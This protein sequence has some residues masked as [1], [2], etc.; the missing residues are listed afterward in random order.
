MIEWKAVDSFRW[1]SSDP[2]ATVMRACPVCSRPASRE[3]VS[4]PGFQY[5]TDDARLSKRIHIRDVVCDACHAVY[6]NPVLTDDGF[7]VLAAEA[8]CSYGASAG[9]SMETLGWLED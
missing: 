9:R 4:F 5:F 8:G 2:K 1:N 7:R 3:A 6:R